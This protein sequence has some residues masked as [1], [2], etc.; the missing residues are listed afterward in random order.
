MEDMARAKKEDVRK[1]ILN[2]ANAVSADLAPKLEL[3]DTLQR[4]GVAHHYREEIAE[5]LRDVHDNKDAREC[6][7]LRISALRF[8]LLRK[9]GYNVSPGNL[10]E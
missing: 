2:V 1:I 4:I 5:L 10:D 9:Q 6:D 3:I 8:Y 7:D